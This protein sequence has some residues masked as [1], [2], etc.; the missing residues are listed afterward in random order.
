VPHTWR[1][2][3]GDL[4]RR[5]TAGSPALRTA[6]ESAAGSPDPGAEFARRQPALDAAPAR[7]HAAL[8]AAGYRDCSA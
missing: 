4:L 7:D 2:R 1:H 5:L 3:H 8:K 6:L